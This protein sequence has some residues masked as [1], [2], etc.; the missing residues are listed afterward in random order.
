MAVSAA[1]M[2]ATAKYKKA[3]IRRLSFEV[4]NE[5]FDEVLKPAIDETGMSINGFIKE[6]IKEYIEN[7]LLD[8]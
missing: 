2:K 3:H 7:H 4:Q 1:H 5:Y 6:A 8:V